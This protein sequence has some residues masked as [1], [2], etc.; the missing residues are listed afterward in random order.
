MCYAPD[1]L[2]RGEDA[3]GPMSFRMSLIAWT[4]MARAN[5]LLE[6]SIGI[7]VFSISVYISFEVLQDALRHEKKR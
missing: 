7:I 5:L 4:F 6:I 2:C 3:G 1:I